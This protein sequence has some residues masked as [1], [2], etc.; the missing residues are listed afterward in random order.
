MALNPHISNPDR[1]EINQLILVPEG[2]NEIVSHDKVNYIARIKNASN[3]NFLRKEIERFG[4]QPEEAIR[5]QKFF[6]KLDRI[7][8]LS[9]AGV[10][11]FDNSGKPITLR[12]PIGSNLKVLVIRND[13]AAHDAVSAEKR[14][15]SELTG[16]VLACSAA[17]LG[18][19]AI[20]SSGVLVPFSGGTSTALTVLAYSATLA[21]GAQCAN[22]GYRTYKLYTSGTEQL[23]WLDSQEWYV[24][25]GLA[26]DTISVA[27]GAGASYTS[28]KTVMT[29]RKAAPH[30]SIFIFSTDYRDRSESAL[31]RN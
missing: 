6:Q 31:R 22:G 13:T 26:L 2:P 3:D 15:I 29:L 28:I 11:Y 18:T 25:S 21:S 23:D 27:G 7:I 1:I 9:G 30:K 19:I 24:Y 10:I 5:R 4:Q 16:A 20:F 12:A 14:L 8:E 17:V